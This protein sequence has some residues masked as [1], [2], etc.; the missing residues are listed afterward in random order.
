[1]N[2]KKLIKNF[3]QEQNC[4]VVY[5]TKYGSKL[6]GTDNP[7]S[8][9]DYKG[10]FIPNKNDVLLKKDL[11]HFNFNSNDENTKNSKDDIDLQLFSVYKFFN[12]LKKGET[13]AMDILFSMFREDTQVYNDKE[14]T[15]MMMES[16]KKFYNRNLHSF[17]GYC[18]GQSKVYNVRG[19]RFNEL[20][21]FVKYFNALVKEQGDEKLKTM[22]PDVD[23]IF[24][25]TPFK[26]IN[27]AIASISR[28]HS[29]T[30]QGKYIEVLGKRF[31]GTVTVKYFAEKI[32]DMEEQFGN[33]A[34][35]SAKGVDF[36]ALSHAVRVINEVEELIDDEFIS[37]PLKNRAYVTSIKEGEESLE[38][39]MEYLDNQL[40]TVQEKLEK[41]NLPE[42]SDEVFIDKLLLKLIVG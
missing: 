32:T 29:G 25:E 42:K 15:S 13:G 20:H 18:V 41:S 1:M 30:K 26:Y 11:E 22:F 5:V 34:R 40:T 6:Y 8:D 9:T 7:N 4:K 23:R 19:E 21:L 2:I 38:D 16:Y 3:E 39:V 33:R 31:L 37:F 28:G 35:A 17:I 12:L 27:Y 14:F 36:K 24:E 10:I